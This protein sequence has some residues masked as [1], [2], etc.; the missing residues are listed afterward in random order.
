MSHVDRLVWRIVAAVVRRS[1]AAGIL[2]AWRIRS[3]A[4]SAAAA[5]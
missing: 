5:A 1:D 4:R 2:V 3:S